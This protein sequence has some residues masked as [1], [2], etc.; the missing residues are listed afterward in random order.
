MQEVI[1][2]NDVIRVCALR[3]V[4]TSTHAILLFNVGKLYVQRAVRAHV[5]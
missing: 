2:K 5:M 4:R 1:V 3:G